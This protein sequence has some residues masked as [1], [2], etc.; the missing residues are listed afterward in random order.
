M[1]EKPRTMQNRETKL[2]DVSICQR[3]KHAVRISSDGIDVPAAVGGEAALVFC[4]RRRVFLVLTILGR[5]LSPPGIHGLVWLMR[6]SR[7]MAITA[8]RPWSLDQ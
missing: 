1:I 8:G 7:L 6:G 4:R 5:Q 2:K 3:R